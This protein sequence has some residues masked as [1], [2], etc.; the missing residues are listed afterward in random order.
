VVERF[1]AGTG[2]AAL[3]RCRLETGRTHQIRVH[4]ADAGMP[5][6]GDPLYGKKPRDPQLGALAVALGRQALHAVRLELAHPITGAPLRFATEP[7]ADMQTLLA[8]LRML[9]PPR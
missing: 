5:V 1:G 8:G 6:L 2:I 4:F 3:V 7:P 9:Q